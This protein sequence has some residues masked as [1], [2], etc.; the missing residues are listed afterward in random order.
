MPRVPMISALVINAP[1]QCEK[2]MTSWPATPGK[3]YL[4]PPENPDDL[5]RE[6]RADDQRHVVIDDRAVQPTSTDWWE[7][8]VGQF[9]DPVG[10]D[11]ATETKVSGFHHSWLSTVVPG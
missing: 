2:S 9:G 7:P 4:L 5:V 6:H 1:S 8:A 3:K 11:R 10:A